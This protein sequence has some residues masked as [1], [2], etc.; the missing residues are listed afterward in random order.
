MAVLPFRN[1]TADVDGPDMMRNK[2]VHALENRSYVVKDLKETDQILRDRMGITLGGQLD[3]ITAQK[4]GETLGV[5]GVL[6]GTLMDFDETTT[7][8]VNIR[9]VRGKFKL[10]SAMT[11]QTLWEQGLGVRSEMMMQSA[12][13]AA[14][15]IVS[16]AADARDKE[17][18]WVTIGS[19]TTG[20]NKLG[21]SLAIGLGT[22]LI[23]KAIGK[24]LDY[25]STELARRITQNLPWGPGAPDAMNK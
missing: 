4:L 15:A 10:V 16:R 17:A 25:E 14:A 1:D 13:G 8:A 23:S 9:K 20:S 18:P 22:R 19:I 3:M 12:A 2:M 11:G 7:G 5:E 21:E 6:Y 24:Q